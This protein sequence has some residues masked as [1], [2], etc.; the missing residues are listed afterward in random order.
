ML[1][2]YSRIQDDR[3]LLKETL[4]KSVRLG[5]F[6]LAPIMIGL[7]SVADN[8]VLVLLTEKWM[9]SVPYI[10]IFCFCCFVFMLSFL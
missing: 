7:A 8:F 1:P 5:L 9:Y 2:V 4:R 10:C 3:L 6:F